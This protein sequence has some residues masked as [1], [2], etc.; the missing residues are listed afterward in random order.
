MMNLKPAKYSEPQRNLRENQ[1]ILD[2]YHISHCNTN[3]ID[4]K[5]VP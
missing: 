1:T 5:F 2:K 4:G 3:E